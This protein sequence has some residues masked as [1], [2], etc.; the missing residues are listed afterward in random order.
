MQDRLGPG[1]AGTVG[2]M[3]PLVALL[4]SI[5]FESFRPDLL[6]GLGAALALAGNALML[7]PAATPEANAAA[8]PLRRAAAAGE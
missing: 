1:P 7:R 3:T 5:G 6:T 8:T 4:V 2:V